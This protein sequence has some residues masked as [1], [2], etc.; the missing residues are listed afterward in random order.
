MKNGQIQYKGIIIID[1]SFKLYD[2]K[3]MALTGHA[4]ALPQIMRP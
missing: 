3:K 4:V 2:I 1:T